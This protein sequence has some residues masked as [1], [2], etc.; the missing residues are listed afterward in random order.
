MRRFLIFVSISALIFSYSI[1]THAV[2]SGFH[3]A[4]LIE[5]LMRLGYQPRA[6][7]FADMVERVRPFTA[8]LLFFDRSSDGSLIKKEVQALLLLAMQDSLL[9]V[10]MSLRMI[11]MVLTLS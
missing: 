6:E 10:V 5:A 1:H 9:Q 4:D 3:R 11:C 7:R 8:D 2:E